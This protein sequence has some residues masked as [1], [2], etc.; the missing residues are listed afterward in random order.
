LASGGW[1]RPSG[2]WPGRPHV[3]SGR[4]LTGNT[5]RL[6]IGSHGILIDAALRTLLLKTLQ[7]CGTGCLLRGLFTRAKLGKCALGDALGDTLTGPGDTLAQ[8]LALLK[9]HTRFGGLDLLPLL[10]EPG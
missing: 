6:D 5:A 4:R 1:W 9:I 8:G 7:H 10:A 3:D 2:S